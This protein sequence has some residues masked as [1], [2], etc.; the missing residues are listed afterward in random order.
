MTSFECHINRITKEFLDKV[1]EEGET[2][3]F[4]DEQDDCRWMYGGHHYF[5]PIANIVA[6]SGVFEDDEDE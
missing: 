5:L 4:K 3:R 2:I 6:L 1:F